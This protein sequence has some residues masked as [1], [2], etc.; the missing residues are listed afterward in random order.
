[1][2]KTKEQLMREHN[3]H[4]S[5]AVKKFKEEIGVEE[6]K[7]LTEKDIKYKE[8][9]IQKIAMQEAISSKVLKE[10]ILNNK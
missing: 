6:D 3:D 9:K 5:S 10:A 4:I 7:I 1:M 8:Y 2:A